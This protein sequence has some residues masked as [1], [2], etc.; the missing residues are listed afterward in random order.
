MPDGQWD[1]RVERT[2]GG[3]T[4]RAGSLPGMRITELEI[5]QV[6]LA[7]GYTT[8]DWSPAFSTL[9]LD[10]MAKRLHPEARLTIRPLD[11]DRTWVIGPTDDAPD[12]VTNDS[13]DSVTTTRSPTVRSSPVRPPT[14]AGG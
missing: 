12:P 3:R 14:S 7:A 6:D 10:A 1:A 11:L 8:A 13:D 5:H 2:P 9:L 4:M